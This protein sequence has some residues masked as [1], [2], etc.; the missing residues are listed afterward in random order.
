MCVCSGWLPTTLTIIPKAIQT[1]EFYQVDSFFTLFCLS[2]Q[3]S[4]LFRS[5][6]YN[7]CCYFTPFS[8]TTFNSLEHLLSLSLSLSIALP[9]SVTLTLS[10]PNILMDKRQFYNSTARKIILHR[11]LVD[12]KC[13]KTVVFF[14]GIFLL[15]NF[16]SFLFTS[17][18]SM[19]V[20]EC[21]CVCVC[22]EPK[23][24]T[25]NKAKTAQIIE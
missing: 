9:D 17:F 1:D 22:H 16:T 3:T 24:E 10:T 12:E 4:Y 18:H 25:S 15:F 13:L 6:I 11:I 21:V 8:T 14:K 2:M 23:R 19:C 5:H 7:I 20:S